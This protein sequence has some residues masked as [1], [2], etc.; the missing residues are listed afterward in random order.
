MDLIYI[1]CDEKECYIRAKNLFEEGKLQL[2]LH[3]LDVII[4]ATDRLNTEILLKAYE[5]KIKILQQKEE[6]ESSFI[7]SNI[8]LNE[9]NRLK[10]KVSNLSSK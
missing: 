2:V 4:N 1:I 6:K 5:L 8:F 3:I 7:A 9:V 10:L